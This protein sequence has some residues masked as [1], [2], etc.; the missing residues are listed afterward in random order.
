[1]AIEVIDD[2]GRSVKLE[3]PAKRIISLAPHVTENLFAAG[4]GHLIV[5]AVNYSDYPEKAKTIPQVGGYNNFNI[6][7][8]LASQAD[9]I[10][11]WKEGNQKQQVEKLI[12]LGMTVYISDPVKLEDVARSI[13]HFGVL[14]GENIIADKASSDFLSK[15]TSLREQYRQLEKVSVF[16]QTWNVPLITVNES[17]SIG[18]V[19]KLCGGKNVFAELDTLTPQVSIEAVIASNP[20]TIIASGMNQS[21]PEWLDDWKKW[22]FLSAV[23]QDHLFFV[24]PDIIQR[25]SPRILQG[26]QMICE[27]LQQ[28]RNTVN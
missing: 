8:I 5:G 7:L 20:T 18:Q 26:A 4:V 27:Y 25:H 15:L 10:I 16:Y 21:R 9:L 1:M 24:P 19:I 22:G 23:K 14:T 13:K 28:A 3:K 12:S 6:E 2:I 11:A 17:Q